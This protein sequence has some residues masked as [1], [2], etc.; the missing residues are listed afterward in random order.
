VL[1]G[2]AAWVTLS[3][4]LGGDYPGPECTSCDFPG[5]A[6]N[7]LAAGH[8]HQFFAVQPV[9][10]SVSLVLRA[11]AAA[12]L[13]ADLWR[14]RVG[15]L[16]LLSIVALLAWWLADVMSRRGASRVA[17]AG[18]AGLL[19]ASPLTFQAMKWG[20]PEE[21]LA[22]ALCIAAVLLADGGRAYSAGVALGLALAT[23]QWAVLAILPVGMIAQGTRTKVLA[24]AA[25]SAAI[26][27]L[28]MLIG[29]A[30]RFLHMASGYAVTNG[31]FMTPANVWWSFGIKLSVLQPA[32]PPVI[33]MVIPGAVKVL[34]HPLLYGVAGAITIAYWRGRGDHGAVAALWLLALIFALRCLLGTLTFDYDHLPLLFAA[35]SA[36]GLGRRRL[37][38]ISFAVAG[39]IW[40]LANAMPTTNP[41]LLHWTYLAAATPLLGYLM[42]QVFGLRLPS[43]R[44]APRT[45]A[46]SGAW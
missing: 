46:V 28:P 26:L 9:M 38:W 5:P 20:H 43:L 11:P 41:T 12:L 4:G 7:A 1:L 39:V 29:D 37:P 3:S 15:A 23:Q 22:A 14:Y 25:I 19:V 10:G 13:H 2:A 8:L 44:R 31:R 30:G 21:A 33:A 36:E 32:G 34:A 27:T 6:I 45:Q 16:V 18:V 24:S 40:L 35:A 42:V 17:Q